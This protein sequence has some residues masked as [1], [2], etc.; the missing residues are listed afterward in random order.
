MLKPMVWYYL[1]PNLGFGSN[2]HFFSFGYAGCACHFPFTFIVIKSGKVFYENS[3]LCV[4]YIHVL[5][6]W[7]T[8]LKKS[9]P[10][11]LKKTSY[12]EER[13]HRMAKEKK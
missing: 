3:F 9:Y 4:Y 11:S 13:N 8:F 12:R 6:L 7:H 10:L 5:L 2:K 1:Q